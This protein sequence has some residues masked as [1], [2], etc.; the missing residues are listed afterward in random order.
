MPWTRWIEKWLKCEK[1]TNFLLKLQT[2]PAF[3]WYSLYKPSGSLVLEAWSD[4]PPLSGTLV[5]YC[6][7]EHSCEASPVPQESRR[8]RCE[9]N[10]LSYGK[11][12]N[13]W[14]ETRTW[15]MDHQ[16][17]VRH[18]LTT[19]PSRPHF[20]IKSTICFNFIIF[21]NCHYLSLY[22]ALLNFFHCPAVLDHLFLLA[23]H[24]FSLMHCS[25]SA[26]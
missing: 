19:R 16:V 4:F 22:L 11:G 15:T 21:V 24:C 7:L 9:V 6:Y 5:H 25:H 18:P 23:M 2:T 10:C 20:L 14:E 17:H 8:K 3:K 26:L 12:F 1:G 13:T